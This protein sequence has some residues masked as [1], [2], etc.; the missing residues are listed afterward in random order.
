MFTSMTVLPVMF[1]QQLTTPNSLIGASII[2]LPTFGT[3]HCSINC[4]LLKLAVQ[5]CIRKSPYPTSATKFDMMMEDPKF[6]GFV[7]AETDKQFIVRFHIHSFVLYYNNDDSTVVI[8]AAISRM[9]IQ[10]MMQDQLQFLQL[11]HH[12][13]FYICRCSVG[14][15][16]H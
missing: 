13:K 3:V 8:C 4:L 5:S 16:F 10:S 1:C 2:S 12:I 9:H 7:A 11:I 6:I 14:I 15:N